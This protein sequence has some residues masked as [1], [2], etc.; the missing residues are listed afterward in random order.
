MARSRR[1]LGNC[2]TRG[3]PEDTHVQAMASVWLEEQRKAWPGQVAL[4]Q[5]TA[6]DA[7]LIENIIKTC[8]IQTMYEPEGILTQ[9]IDSHVITLDDFY[10]RYIE[11][12]GW[13]FGE[14]DYDEEKA[15]RTGEKNFQRWLTNYRISLMGRM[16]EASL[17]R[18]EIE[19]NKSKYYLLD[20]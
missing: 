11:R 7:E 19:N 2:I 3:R 15:G 6:T 12:G 9:E 10:W 18:W 13:I 14:D 8:I 4:F 5:G 17:I 16:S 1:S 20:K